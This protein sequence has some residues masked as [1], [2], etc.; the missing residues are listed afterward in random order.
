MEEINVI[1]LGTA[2]L[3][4]RSYLF[5]FYKCALSVVKETRTFGYF[6]QQGFTGSFPI[7][8]R[9]CPH[10][11]R[12]GAGGC[13]RVGE[14][15]HHRLLNIFWKYSQLHEGAQGF[16]EFPFPLR[17][18]GF[19]IVLVQVPRI[20]MRHFVHQCYKKHIAIEIAIDGDAVT[21]RGMI[22]TEVAMYRIARL[23][24]L[25]MA[26]GFPQLDA[27]EFERRPGNKSLKDGL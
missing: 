19:H 21:V 14:I 1:G 8:P 22:N 17:S 20:E 27:S 15:T 16:P 5:P 9:Q 24:D 3:E 10:E 7:V 2:A 25:Y 18:M 11:V 26:R 12:I 6:F 13:G 4:S 23:R